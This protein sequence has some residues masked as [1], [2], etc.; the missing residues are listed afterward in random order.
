MTQNPYPGPD[1]PPG[2]SPPVCPRHPD[3]VSYVGCA[4]CRRPTCPECQRPAAVGIQCV[5]C[6]AEGQRGVRQPTT[7]MGAP[8]AQ[9]PTLTYGLIA[10]CVVL[11]VAQQADSGVTQA[12]AYAPFLTMDEPW[13]MLTAAFVHSPGNITHLAFNMF[14]L[15]ICGREL[16]PLLGRGKFAAVYLV[17]ALGGSFGVLAL[18]GSFPSEGW[19]RYTVGASGAVFGLFAVLLVLNRHLGRATGGIAIVLALNFAL[20]FI[21]P[22]IAWQAHLG[23]A[24]TGAVLAAGL[25]WAAP[26]ER[27][28]FQWPVLLFGAAVVLVGTLVRL[29]TAGLIG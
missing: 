18:A 28:R 8:V 1:G 4:R 3:R 7:A 19:G 9:R 6:V 29:W 13:R 25:A 2:Q 22:N 16:E 23:G 17:S 14:A 27:R 12:L 24:V 26:R 5:D 21:L 10:I 15:F 11:W 20:G